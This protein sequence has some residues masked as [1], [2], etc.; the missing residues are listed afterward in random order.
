MRSLKHRA[1]PRGRVTRKSLQVR[2]PA[3]KPL[4][5]H[6]QIH[7]QC[8]TRTPRNPDC[9]TTLRQHGEAAMMLRWHWGDFAEGRGMWPRKQGKFYVELFG[10]RFHHDDALHAIAWARAAS[11]VCGLD[12]RMYTSED[13]TP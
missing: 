6:L 7:P 5:L 3:G 11:K 2:R 8:L 4:P 12:V 1:T 13:Q 10:R 9:A